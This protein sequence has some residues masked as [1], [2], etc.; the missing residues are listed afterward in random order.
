MDVNS[1]INYEIR[2]ERE[3]ADATR[4]L[5]GSSAWRYSPPGGGLLES[6]ARES[7]I[8]CLLEETGR[9]AEVSPQIFERYPD[10]EGVS[11]EL[12]RFAVEAVTKPTRRAD[13]PDD[14]TSTHDG[15]SP[16]LERHWNEVVG[17][18]RLARSKIEELEALALFHGT[19]PLN[20]DELA[21]GKE[22]IYPD[23]RYLEATEVLSHRANAPFSLRFSYQNGWEIVPVPIST[24]LA[25][26]CFQESTNVGF[27][28]DR[29]G[30]AGNILLALSPLCAA[31]SNS[32]LCGARLGRRYGNRPWLWNRSLHPQCKSSVFSMGRYFAYRD[33]RCLLEWL[34]FVRSRRSLLRPTQAGKGLEAFRPWPTLKTDS[35]FSWAQTLRPSWCELEE[36][37]DF[38]W[39]LRGLD[40]QLTPM[41][42]F[43]LEQLLVGV[44]LSYLHAGLEDVTEL[45]SHNCMGASYLKVLCQGPQ[46]TRG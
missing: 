19:M 41:M 4:R 2:A 1:A 27:A 39:E 23:D 42:T 18:V 11:P 20:P 9:L 13:V 7:E 16:F 36:K 3:L 26:T 5:S 38:W 12:V 29:M 33:A 17:G 34:Q 24:L 8:G 28:S 31:F 40:T 6:M 43:A 22:L 21:R 45:I 35:G 10:L 25:G 30:V 46:R 14:E 44:A 15:V 37:I 32:A